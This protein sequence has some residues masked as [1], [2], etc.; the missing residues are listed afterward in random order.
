MNTVRTGGWWFSLL[1]SRGHIPSG[2]RVQPSVTNDHHLWSLQKGNLGRSPHHTQIDF[3]FVVTSYYR[4]VNGCIYKHIG[5]V[6]IR[7]IQL[8]MV[9][10]G[11]FNVTKSRNL[12]NGSVM[13]DYTSHP[14]RKYNSNGLIPKYNPDLDKKLKFTG[15]HSFPSRTLNFWAVHMTSRGQ[16]Y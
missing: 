7:S 3:M 11:F 15:D 10:N 8:F 12:V 2:A 1:Y 16:F 6:N 9:N 13:I 14:L 5:L 4:K